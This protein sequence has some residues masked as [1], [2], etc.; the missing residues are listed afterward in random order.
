MYML[1]HWEARDGR[2]WDYEH[3]LLQLQHKLI[4]K[5]L[6]CGFC[7]LR[8]CGVIHRPALFFE[9]LISNRPN[10]D[11]LF[12]WLLHM[13]LHWQKTPHQTPFFYPVHMRKRSKAISFVRLFVCLFVST[14]IATSRVLGIWATPKHNE[15]VDIGEKLAALCFELFDR[16][17]KRHK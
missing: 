16:A 5:W 10:T 1:Y 9:R 15:S 14:K 4:L 12:P 7:L 3:T 6:K 17:Y 13:I 2:I 8:M 11:H